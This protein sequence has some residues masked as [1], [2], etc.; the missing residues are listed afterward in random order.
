MKLERK[1][2]S[3][4]M[5]TLLLIGMLTLAFNIQPDKASGTIYIRADGSVDPPDAP[6]YTEDNIT[7]TFTDNIYDEIVVERSNII[8]DGNG[9]TLEG[10]GSGNGFYWYGINNV[11]IQNTN[12]QN[13]FLGVYVVSSSFN[14]VSGNNIATC[15]DGIWLAYSN[16]SLLSGN[17]ITK[18]EFSGIYL[19]G[20]YNNTVSGNNITYSVRGIELWDGSNNSISGNKIANN[21]D[22]IFLGSFFNN[23]VSGNN[24]TNN[25]NGVYLNGAYDNKF[26]HNNL[27]DNL[28]QV[29]DYGWVD[30]MI[31]PSLNIWDDGYPSGG[32]YWSDYT[33]V[34]LY[35]GPYQNETGSDG[36][37][38]T[39]YVIDENNQDNFPLMS[40]YEY[41]SNPIPGDIN[42][43]MKVDY[44]DLFQLAAAYGSTPEKP[45]WNPHADLNNDDTVD[46]KDLFILSTNYG[47]EWT[48]NYRA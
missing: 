13:F 18:I 19:G 9:Y 5:L 32:N 30:P 39:P 31:P 16:N 23:T 4:I 27:I 40:P 33:G 45:N 25:N 47:K 38:D 7:Y 3:G 2:V 21:N 35:S 14:T 1:T 26:Y 6:I 12:I 20:S 44:K 10:S 36:I 15:E 24:I 8:I 42:K 43:D 28:Q 46:C 17:N 22:G 29:Y 37:G 48:E 41:W 11:T 34:D